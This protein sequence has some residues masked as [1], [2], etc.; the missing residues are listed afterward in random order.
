MRSSFNKYQPFKLD[1]NKAE[2]KLRTAA[3]IYNDNLL[4]MSQ[5]LL[6]EQLLKTYNFPETI[7][8]IENILDNIRSN[9]G[10]EQTSAS[11]KLAVRSLCSF[12]M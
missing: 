7:A 3:T 1:L 4:R 12:S 6:G 2:S 5:N 11:Y 10:C 8:S 9:L